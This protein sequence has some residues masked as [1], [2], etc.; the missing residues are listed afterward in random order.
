MDN[1]ENYSR[2]LNSGGNT[3]LSG[4]LYPLKIARQTRRF[5]QGAIFYIAIINEATSKYI[6][7]P[8]AM[9][10]MWLSFE[11]FGYN[12]ETWETSWECLEEYFS[13]FPDPASRHAMIAMKSHWDWYVTHLGKFIQFSSQNSLDQ[14]ISPALSEDL[15]MIGFKSITKQLEILKKTTHLNFNIPNSYVESLSEMTLVRNLG[16]HSQWEVD[17]TYLRWSKT[18][19]FKLGEQRTFTINELNEWYRILASLID[20]TASL[21]AAKFNHVPE[22][23]G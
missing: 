15:D 22:F 18:R 23:S 14:P 13:A 7:T 9:Q 4:H 6:Q 20:I 12:E 21:I 17:A 2:A 3:N 8:G 1:S 19:G 10:E 11:T 5:M 16:I